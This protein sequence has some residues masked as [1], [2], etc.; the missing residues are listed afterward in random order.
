MTKRSLLIRDVTHSQLKTDVKLPSPIWTILAGRGVSSFDETDYKL[1]RMLPV[2]AIR[3][4]SEA[5]KL[6]AVLIKQNK[7]ILIF[8]DYDADGATSTAL[9]VRALTLMGHNNVSYLMPDRFINGYGLSVSIADKI[10]EAKP[11]CVITVD[12]GIASI[13]GIA[14]LRAQNIDVIVTDHHLPADELPNASVIINQN[15]WPDETVGKNLAGVGVAFYLMLGLRKALRDIDWFQQK[16]GH[17]QRGTQQRIEPN[18]ANCLDLVAIG[19]VADLVP[20]DFHNRLLVNEGLRRIRAGHC[21]AGIQ[22][23]IEISNKQLT[24]VTSTDIGFAIAPKIN[25]AGRL[26]D[27]TSG[28]QCLLADDQMSADGFANQLNDINQLR[29]DIQQ[30]MADEAQLQLARLSEPELR[31]SLGIVLF[32]KGWHE[33]IVGIVASKV[34]EKYHRPCIVFAEAEDGSLKGSG[35]SIS[36]IHL[37]DILDV[38]DKRY[39]GIIL[40]FGGHAM[41]AGLS[42]KA[43]SFDLFSTAFQ[44]VITDLVDSACFTDSIECDGLLDSQY[45]T[46]DFAKTIQNLT[47]W[48]Q[49][50]PSPSFVGEFEVT[51]SRIL[52]QKHIKF[53]LKQNNDTSSNRIEAIAFFQPTDVLEANHD[54][55]HIHY[56]L[57]INYFRNRESLQLLIR[58]IL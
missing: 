40:K 39:P 42:L 2:E 11:D 5:A 3:N 58:D 1:S 27:M 32:Q 56:E 26:E 28:V 13:D 44:S 15:A 43:D 53:E 22:S 6:L 48:G 46:I 55:I 45:M 33:G 16:K 34:K 30:Q 9:C 4:L 21:C 52:A 7:S 31:A 37:R 54:S 14:L 36:G 24:H 38:V 18:L 57:N 25:A 35:R 51:D 17:Q 47:P 20:L 49:R 41:A 10:V 50:F 23:L 8:G 29:K 19:T 12:N